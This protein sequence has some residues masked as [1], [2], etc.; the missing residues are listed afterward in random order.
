MRRHAS[1]GAKQGVQ[2]H[3]INW[4]K[5]AATA[6]CFCIRLTSFGRRK[7]T[8][9]HSHRSAV[10][11]C[12]WSLIL[13]HT[14][15]GGRKRILQLFVQQHRV[16]IHC[17]IRLTKFPSIKSARFSLAIRSSVF[18]LHKTQSMHTLLI[19]WNCLFCSFCFDK[20]SQYL[21]A[22]PIINIL[23][24]VITVISQLV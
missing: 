19:I 11:M 21:Y 9:A 20:F 17:L 2:T 10:P 3:L 22:K 5:L 12:S 7:N 18:H 15:T 6:F 23:I 1:G 8:R 13:T 14:A 4:W 24:I 16:M